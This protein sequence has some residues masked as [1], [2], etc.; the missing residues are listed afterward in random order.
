M[1]PMDVRQAGISDVDVVWGILAE[2]AAWLE[3]AGMGMWRQDEV[4][5]ERIAAEVAAGQFFLGSRGGEPVAT[6]KFQ[7]QDPDFWPGVAAGEAV[8]IHRLAVRRA[9]AGRGG[10]LP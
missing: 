7:L 3:R 4:A 9:H 10:R 6:I 8:Y 5:P 1:A 2:A